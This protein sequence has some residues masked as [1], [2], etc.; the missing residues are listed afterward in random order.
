MQQFG[1]S[2]GGYFLFGLISIEKDERRRNLF[3]HVL[4]ISER[5]SKCCF[6]GKPYDEQGDLGERCLVPELGR[7][8]CPCPFYDKDIKGCIYNPEKYNR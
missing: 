7:E 8:D 2:F 1:Y 4:N 3:V 6:M 5:N